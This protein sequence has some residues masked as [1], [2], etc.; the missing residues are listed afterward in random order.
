MEKIK[1]IRLIGFIAIL[2]LFFTSCDNKN[3]LP[4]KE[5]SGKSVPVRIHS[6]GVAEGSSESL[7]RSASQKEPKVVSQPIGDGM[8]LEMNVKEDESPLRKTELT[9]GAYFR[10]IAVKKST[11]E[12][13][14]HGDFVYGNPSS[15]LTDFHVKVGES[16]D[17]ICFSYNKTN[18]TLPSSASYKVGV[19]LPA[20]S[21]TINTTN[22][23]PLWCKITEIGMVPSTGVE[24]DITMKHLLAKVKVKVDCLYNGWKITGVAANQVAVVVND[25]SKNCTI[26]WATGI[27]SGTDMDQGLTYIISDPARTDQTSN[28]E[29]IIPKGSN[30]VVKIK[31]GAISRGGYTDIPTS[32]KS[33]T[34]TKALTGGVSYTIHVRVRTP[35]WAR[36]NIY[37]DNSKLTFVPAGSDVSKE[38]Y[39]GV[40]FKWGSL[41]GVS[42]ND[43][44]YYRPN[45]SGWVSQ[46]Y[47]YGAWP[48]IISPWD[49]AT[50]G[51]VLNNLHTEE[52][53]GDICRYL[54]SGYRLPTGEECSIAGGWTVAGTV[55][56][57]STNASGT[58]DLIG[59]GFFYAE[60]TSMGNVRFP[61]AGSMLIDGQSRYTARN[62]S[63]WSG[64]LTSYSTTSSTGLSLFGGDY[65]V[66]PGYGGSHHQGF[67]IRCVQN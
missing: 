18:N 10:V 36:S 14:S 65:M 53:L 62:G 57:V 25:P 58:Y 13:Y 34:F 15:L 63:Y 6:L 28:E 61:S 48:T 41:V 38:G 46:S 1:N 31:I 11:T 24:L 66:S 39:Q 21:L 64:S 42:P 16:Y 45:G 4:N 8:L 29:T 2:A 27:V 3:E 47:P 40:Y 44:T 22:D 37:W 30:A 43:L 35:I 60:N 32:A 50:Y 49:V 56:T 5:L 52:F 26:D 19:A 20:L 17:Y 7:V 67:S 33:V 54:N 12:Y 51:N 55:G 9:E 23:D 59:N